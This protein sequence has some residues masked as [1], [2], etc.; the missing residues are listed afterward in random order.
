[1]ITWI[2]FQ[3]ISIFFDICITWVKILDGI[4]YD[5]RTSLNMRI[6]AGHVTKAFL[7]FLM[8]IFQLE[9]SNL[10]YKETLWGHIIC[11]PD[12]AEFQYLHF[13]GFF[14]AFLNEPGCSVIR[15]WCL[16]DNL[17]CFH[18]ISICFWYLDYG[19]CLLLGDILMG[20]YPLTLQ[21][22]SSTF[23]KAWVFLALIISSRSPFQMVA[24]LIVKKYFP[25]FKSITP[26]EDLIGVA[27]VADIP[28]VS[29]G[30]TSLSYTLDKIL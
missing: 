12:F 25:D 6:M 10:I 14:Y 9:P 27:L 5:H 4:E 28:L 20:A 7:A 16:D 13:S 3:R 24:T 19:P 15:A 21:C 2:L 23:F 29:M 26:F 18:W 17:N 22:L 1:M 11:I 30:P 8:S